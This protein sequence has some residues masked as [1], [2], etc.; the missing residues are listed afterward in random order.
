M[1]ATSVG[2]GRKGDRVD[3]TCCSDISMTKRAGKVSLKGQYTLDPISR[4]RMALLM[5]RTLSNIQH[6]DRLPDRD[7]LKIVVG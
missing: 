2:R 6:S 3:V 1:V 7:W 5:I 4:R